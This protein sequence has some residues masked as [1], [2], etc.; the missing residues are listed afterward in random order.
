VLLGSEYN[1]VLL[2][3]VTNCFLMSL[4]QRVVNI[5]EALFVDF[6]ED[7]QRLASDLSAIRIR[8]FQTVLQ[9]CLDNAV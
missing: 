8:I 1:L 7:K 3:I 2:C 6:L 9:E 4:V 5:V